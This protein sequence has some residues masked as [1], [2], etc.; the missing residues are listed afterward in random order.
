MTEEYTQRLFGT[1]ED[2]VLY[3]SGPVMKAAKLKPGD[4]LRITPD[5][6]GLIVQ[7]D[8]PRPGGQP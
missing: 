2:G 3:L 6:D 7:L 5:K 4:K 1:P 8:T